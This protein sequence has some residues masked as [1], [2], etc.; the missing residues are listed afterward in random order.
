MENRKVLKPTLANFVVPAFIITIAALIRILPHPPNL[1]PIAAMA[2]FGGTYLP[3]KYAFIIPLGAMFVS[4]IFI[5]FHSLVVYV[6]GS[7]VLI[8]LI[9]MW[10]AENK[11]V[12]NI[13]LAA[14]IS[15]VLFFVVTNFGVWAAGAYARDASGLLESYILGLPFFRNTLL[16]DF[17][18]TGI[19]FG[20]YE[21]VKVKIYGYLYKNR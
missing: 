5:G 13:A 8:G 19:F 20:L 1:T 17:F 10:L 11:N 7:F 16:G 18:Y 2:L 21:L 15:S 4:D 14:L 9:G 12:R 3:K 6:Y